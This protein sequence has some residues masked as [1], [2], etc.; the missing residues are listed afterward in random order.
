MPEKQHLL[1]T[2]PMMSSPNRSENITTARAKK[3]VTRTARGQTHSWPGCP[4]VLT[5][6]QR[7]TGQET[8]SVSSPN[9]A[10]RLGMRL[11][12]NEQQPPQPQPDHQLTTCNSSTS[13]SPILQQ[14][15]PLHPT[16]CSPCPIQQQHR[17]ARQQV[18]CITTTTTRPVRSGRRATSMTA[19]SWS[20][21]ILPR[22]QLSLPVRHRRR[23]PHSTTSARPPRRFPVRRRR[24]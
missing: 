17:Q 22:G 7:R 5:P 8:G 19:I 3:R 1:T 11:T 21:T 16:T 15:P 4:T 14:Q 23:H 12:E 20:A 2:V 18:I 13:V 6:I 9:G 10:R 24:P